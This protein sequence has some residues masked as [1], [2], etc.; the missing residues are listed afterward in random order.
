MVACACLRA[1]RAS[2]GVRTT[3]VP[4]V[5]AAAP[6][7]PTRPRPAVRPVCLV[8]RSMR[9][10]ARA[11][12]LAPSGNMRS[13][14]AR[15]L[16]VTQHVPPAAGVAPPGPHTARH[17]TPTETTRR[18]IPTSALRCV[19]MDTT[20]IRRC[21]AKHATPSVAHA[22]AAHPAI[23]SHAEPV[24]LTNM[25]PL[26]S[27]PTPVQPGPLRILLARLVRHATPRA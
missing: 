4:Y 27:P 10:R 7:A 23:V 11:R 5:T 12:T 19:R 15:V 14:P 17:A 9:N 21:N 6:L 2:L 20:Q 13:P 22:Q 8:D 3:A 1:R 24:H 25:A 26:V 16:R 18:C